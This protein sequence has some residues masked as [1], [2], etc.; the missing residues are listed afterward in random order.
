MLLSRKSIPL[1]T[2][3]ENF[4][5]NTVSTHV[6]KYLRYSLTVINI[7]RIGQPPVGGR[8][9]GENRKAIAHTEIT[10]TFLVLPLAFP[11]FVVPSPLSVKLHRFGDIMHP[12]YHTKYTRT[13]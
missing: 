2:R 9:G 7:N 12:V 10:Q 13:M 1:E 6:A 3:I 11:S 8:E 5:Q 4:P